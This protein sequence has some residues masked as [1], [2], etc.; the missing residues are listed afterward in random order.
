MWPNTNKQQ[1]QQTGGNPPPGED[2]F[3]RTANATAREGGTYPDPGLYPVLYVDRLQMKRS[4]RNED[5]FI[6][7][8]DI[9]ESKVPSRP[10]GTQMDWVVNYRHDASP[11]NVKAFFLAMMNLKDED[12][13]ADGLRF[14][15]SEDQPCRGRLVRM[16]ATEQTT[17]AGGIFTACNWTAIPDEIQNKADELRT[18]AGFAPF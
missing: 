13:D 8:F 1:T 15:V 2:P 9:V 6:A 11:G 18:A 5:V 4:R 10:A 14:A 3:N 16:Q 17:Q 12:L 7:S